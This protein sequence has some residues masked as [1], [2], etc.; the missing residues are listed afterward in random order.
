MVVYLTP[1]K[2]PLTPEGGIT[3]GLVVSNPKS[4]ESNGSE[5]KEQLPIIAET[6]PAPQREQKN[7]TIEVKSKKSLYAKAEIPEETGCSVKEVVTE[8]KATMQETQLAAAEKLRTQITPRVLTERD[9]P[10]TRPENLKYT[11]EE[12]ALMKKQA[13]EAYL[14]W[15]ELELEIARYNQEQTALK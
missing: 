11:K 10:I 5:V 14:K 6:E 12:L 2:S 15:I 9:I 8:E 4:Q 3:N 1:P 13:N 7:H